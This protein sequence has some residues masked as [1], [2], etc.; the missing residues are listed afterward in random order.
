MQRRWRAAQLQ[1]LHDVPLTFDPV[2]SLSLSFLFDLPLSRT[3]VKG[4]AGERDSRGLP[5]AIMSISNTTNCTQPRFCTGSANDDAD[6]DDYDDVDALSPLPLYLSFSR[7]P[8]CVALLNSP[9]AKSYCLSRSTS[10]YTTHP[11]AL[12]YHIISSSPRITA[13]AVE[14]SVQLLVCPRMPSPPTP[15]PSLAGRTRVRIHVSLSDSETHSQ[16]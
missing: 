10:S 13:H 15:P 8:V 9:R 12:H 11:G 5:P 6:D 3:A 7:S 16:L 1:V 14:S 2:E 4:K